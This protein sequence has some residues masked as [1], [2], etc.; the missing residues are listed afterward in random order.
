MSTSPKPSSP[1][2]ASP[3][4]FKRPRPS[5]LLM[6]LLAVFGGSAGIS[7]AQN[8]IVPKGTTATQLIV[9]GNV[10]SITTGTLHGSTALNAF[11]R[12]EVDRN[13]T[14]NLV[15]PSK[16]SVLLNMVTDAPVTINGV[17]NSLK[18]GRIG[19]NVVFADPFGM[20]VGASGVLNVGSLLVTTPT[21]TF[22]DG[23]IGSDGSINALSVSALLGGTAPDS[24]LGTIRIDGQVNARDVI[25]LQGGDVSVNGALRAGADVAHQA[26]FL[27][28]VNADSVAGG[29][30]LVENNGAIEIVASGDV[31]IGGRL[32]VDGAAGSPAGA[33]DVRAGHDLTVAP[34][35]SVSARGQGARSDGGTVYLMAAHDAL[36]GKAARLDASAGSSGNGGFIEFSAANKVTIDGGVM[37]AGAANGQA[38]TVL[39][40]P[41]TITWYGSGQDQLGTDGTAIALSATESITLDDVV[42]SSRKVD[43]AT[44]VT[45]ANIETLASTGASGNI[46]LSAPSI[47]LSGG[48]RLLAFDDSATAGA[49][50]I[51]RLEATSNKTQPTLGTATATSSILLRNATIKGND[52]QLVAKNTVDSR[53]IT[54]GDAPVDQAAGL[55]VTAIQNVLHIGAELFGANLVFSD[56]VAKATVTVG[57]GSVI[58]ARRTAALTAENETKAGIAHKYDPDGVP[59]VA[60]FGIGASWVSNESVATVVVETGARITAADLTIRAHNDASLTAQVKAPEVNDAGQDAVAIALNAT[61]A[62]VNAIARVDKG[63]TLQVSGA[64]QVAATN[65][66]NFVNETETETGAEGKGAASVAYASHSSSTNAALNANVGDATSVAILSVNEVQQDV[67]KASASVGASAAGDLGDQA[68]A[69]T[70]G[71]G[72]QAVYEFLGLGSLKLKDDLAPPGAN[73]FRIGGAIAI[74]NNSHTATA[75]IGAGANV[76]AS[77][78]ALVAARVL[79]SDIQI[80]A[81]SSAVSQAANQAKVGTARDAYSAGLAVANIT[82]DAVASVGADAVVTAPRIA[83]SADTIVPVR[84]S[85]LFGSSDAINPFTRWDGLG[86]ITAALGSITNIGDVFNAASSAKA[87]GDGTADSK[88]IYGSVS[89]LTMNDHARAEIGSGARLRVTGHAGVTAAAPWD[90]TLVLKPATPNDSL[91]GLT[92][93]AEAVSQTFSYDAPVTVSA[94]YDATYLFLAGQAPGSGSATGLGASI[95]QSTINNVTQAIV[96]EGAVIEGV[97]EHADSA[98]AGKRTWTIDAVRAADAVAVRATSTPRVISLATAGGIGATFGINGTLTHTELNSDVRALIDDEAIVRARSLVLSAT[99]TPVLWSIAGSLN[100]ASSASVGVG[101]AINKVTTTA[102]AEI[103]DNDTL[104]TD[105]AP[106][107]SVLTRSGTTPTLTVSD[108][109]VEARSGGTVGAASVAGSLAVNSDNKDPGV[110]DK[111]KAKYADAITGVSGIIDTVTLKGK[112]DAPAASAAPAPAKKEP[113]FTFAGA[114]SASANQTEMRTVARI[115]GAVIDQG[116]ATG[117]HALVVRAVGDADI[118]AA[119]GSAA[120]ALGRS[121]SSKSST[122]IAGGVSVNQL[123]NG[124]SADIV[125][126]TVTHAG[127]VTVQALTGGEQL[128]VAIA[129]AVNVSGP[130]TDTSNQLVGSISVTQTISDD[131][132]DTE[133]F[134]R[135]HVKNSSITADAASGAG[136]ARP[137]LDVTAYNRSFIGTGGGSLALKISP[138]KSETG[139]AAGVAFSFAQINT[140]VVAGIDHAKVKAFETIDVHAW[141]ATEIAAGAAFVGA[142][143]APEANSFAGSTVVSIIGNNTSASIGGDATVEA[144]GKVS[145]QAAD[146]GANAALETLIDPDGKRN[147]TA[148][149]LDYCGSVATGLTPSGSC[150]TSVAGTIQVSAGSNYGLSL[151]YNAISN[152]TSASIGQ[153]DVKAT[154]ANGTIDVLASADTSVLSVA[155]GVALSQKFAGAGSASLNFI[156]N[157]VSATVGD[158]NATSQ[159]AVLNAATIRVKASD[160]S[161]VR[162]LGGQIAVGK[163]NAVGLALTVNDS[164]GKVAADVVNARLTAA[165]GLSVEA[166]N[167]ARI[168][169]IAVSGAVGTSG[170]AAGGSLAFNFIDNSTDASL[171]GSSV[172]AGTAT[173]GNAV[174]VIAADSSAIRSLSGAAAFSSKAAGGVALS[175]NSIDNAS[176][177]RINGSQLTGVDT[178]ALNA[179]LDSDIESAAIA[180][181]VGTSAF[182]LAGSITLNEIG[183]KGNVASAELQDA[184]VTTAADPAH[185]SIDVSATDSSSIASLAGAVGVGK[186]AGFGAGVADNAIAT[187]V[188]ARV[189]DSSIHAA[190]RLDIAGSS[191]A[192]IESVAVAGAGGSVGGAGSSSTNRIANKTYADLLDAQVDGSRADVRVTA[193]DKASIDSLAGAG[194]VGGTA[195]AG[196]SLAV[197]LVGGAGHTQTAQARVSGTRAGS[198]GL[199][200]NNLL[201]KA[202]SASTIRTIAAAG[203]GGATGGVGGSV[204]TNIVAKDVSAFIDAGARVKAANNI[205]VLAGADDKASVISGALGIGGSAGIGA[206]S[207]FNQIDGS[208]RAYVD[209]AS[210]TLDAG[211]R[212]AN[213]TISVNS[214]TLAHPVEVSGIQAPAAIAA[215]LSETQLAVRGLA[216]SASSHQSVNNNA[217]S[218]GVGTVGVAVV[219]VI[220]LLGGETHAFIHGA[221]VN[222]LT[223]PAAGADVNVLA[224]SHGFAGNFAL[225]AAGGKGAATSAASSSRSDRNTSAYVTDATIGTAAT[226]TETAPIETVTTVTGGA[227]GS[228]G[229]EEGGAPQVS[230]T[231]ITRR[232]LTLAPSV[233]A[234]KVQA[235]ASQATADIVSGLAGGL[236]AGTATGAVTIFGGA[237]AAYLEGGKVT[238]DSLAVD[239]R[240]SSAYNMLAISAA[241]GVVGMGGAVGVGVADATTDAHVGNK[242]AATRST[243]LQLGGAL[244]V[245]ALTDNDFNAT[246]ASGT[247]AGAAGVAGTAA[248]TVVQNSTSAG[249]YNVAT[250]AVAPAAPAATS[251]TDASGNVVVTSDRTGSGLLP[252][253]LGAVTVD[254]RE[255]I[256]IKPIA[257]AVAVAA[258]AGVGAAANVVV[259]KSSVTGEILNSAVD[260][261]ANVSVKANSDKRIDMTGL[262]GGA[263]QTLGIGGALGVLVVGSGA[264]GA[265]GAELDKDN[266]GT[267]SQ[268]NALSTAPAGGQAANTQPGQRA[269]P[270]FDVKAAVNG[271]APDAVTARI[272]GGSVNGKAVTVAA[273]A[274]TSTGN[275]TGA[276]GASAVLG[277]GGAVGVSRVYS[278]VAASIEAASVRSGS[279][280]VHALALDG[281]SG[282]SSSVTAY[283]GG[284]G[285]VGLG[286]AVSDALI[287]NT[288]TAHADG[289]FTG[290]ASGDMRVAAADNS[291][292]ATDGVGAALGAAAVGIVVSHADKRSSVDAT[293]GNSSSVAG[294]NLLA[295]QAT[296]SAP[297]SGNTVEATSTGAAGGLLAAGAGAESVATNHTRVNAAIGNNVRLPDGNV[298]IVAT[299]DS[300]QEAAATGVAGAGLV[301]ASGAVARASS[302]SKGDH[303]TTTATLGENAVTSATRAGYLQVNASGVDANTAMAVAAAGGVI[304]G[305]AS[306]AITGGYADVNA[307]IGSGASVHAGAITVSADHI[308]SHYDRA[309]SLNAS[310]LGGSGASAS[311]MADVTVGATVGNDSKLDAMSNVQVLAD[312]LF[313]NGTGSR[314]DSASGAGGGVLNAAAASSNTVITA[315]TN[316][317]LGDRVAINSGP[318]ATGSNYSLLLRAANNM[319]V[320]DRVVLGTGGAIAGAAVASHTTANLNSDVA[321]GLANQLN[322]LAGIGIGSYVNAAAGN[323][324]YVETHGL[325][326][327]G[328]ADAGTAITANQN[329]RIGG[330]NTRIRAFGN[331]DITAGKDPSGDFNTV[332]TGNAN[333]Q[334]Y[335]Q[336]LVAVPLADAATTLTSNATLDIA[337]GAT[338]ES[339]QNAVVGAWQ[340]ASNALANGT[341]HGYELGFIPVT[342]GNSSTSTPSSANVTINGDVNAGI[343]HDLRITIENCQ[344]S[345]IYCSRYTQSANS[346]PTSVAFVPQFDAAAYVRA[347]FTDPA[348]QGLMLT[349]VATQPVGAINIGALYA[350][351]GTVTVNAATLQGKGALSSYGAPTIQVIN[352]SPD[353]LVLD[354]V[355]IPNTPGGEV[356]FSGTAGRSTALANQMRLTESGAGQVPTISVQNNY[357]GH[358]G[359]VGYGPAMMLGG[360]ITN[361]GGRI[362]LVN[363][364]GSVG[365]NAQVLGQQVNIDAPNAVFVAQFADS[366]G[367]YYAGSNPY[368]EWQKAMIWPGNNPALAL[369]LA[370]LAI[371][372]FASSIQNAAAFGT[373]TEVFNRSFVHRAG[374]AAGS[375][376][377]LI[378]YGSG[379]RH[380]D[381]QGVANSLSPIGQSLAISNQGDSYIP[382]VPMQSLTKEVASYSGADLSGS[383]A[384]SIIFGS[385]VAIVAKYI[386]V[387]GKITAGQPT[388]WSVSLPASLAGMFA[389]VTAAYRAGRGAAT[390]KID[391]KLLGLVSIGDSPIGATFDVVTQQIILDN[392]SASSGGGSVL[393]NGQILSTNPLGNIHVNGG[394]GKVNIDNQTGYTLKLQDVGAG[395]GALLAGTVGKVEIIDQSPTAPKHVLYTYTPGAGVQTYQGSV[396]QTADQLVA[397]GGSS[398]Q[399]AANYQPTENA[400]WEWTNTATLSRDITYANGGWTVIASNWKFDGNPNEPWTHSSGSVVMGSPGAPVFKETISGSD[401]RTTSHWFGYGGCD[402]A[403]YQGECNY[404]FLQTN[405]STNPY[406]G[407]WEYRYVTGAKLTLTSSVKADNPIKIDF[408]GNTSG[409]VSIKSNGAVQLAGQVINPTGTTTI[410]AGTAL[411]QSAKSSLATRDLTLNAGQGIGTSQQAIS[412]TLADNGVLNASAGAA[413]IYL[414]LAN[415]ATIGTVTAGATGKRGDVRITAGDALL[416]GNTGAANVSGNNITLSSSRGSVGND[417][418]PM[419]ISAVGNP[420]INGAL[421][422]V[423]NVA[424]HGDIKLRQVGGDLL[425]AQIA[426]TGN[427]DVDIA[428]TN[429][430]IYDARGQ[431]AANTLSN[432]Q[433]KQVWDALKLT[434]DRGAETGTRTDASVVAF[435]AQV[436]RDYQKFWD[437]RQ[438]GSLDAGGALLLDP[439]NIELL[440]TL[441]TAALKKDATNAEVVDYANAQYQ[442]AR[443]ALGNA[444]ALNPGYGAG[445]E[446]L[447]DFTRYNRQFT[448]AASSGQIAQLTKNAVWNEAQLSYSISRSALEPTPSQQVGGATPNIIGH[449]ISIDTS[450]AIGKLAPVV[451]ISLAELTS[452]AL[453]T[454]QKAALGLAKAPG[455]IK[456]TGVDDQ[457]RT[458]V[459]DFGKE[460]AGIKLTGFQLAQTSPL[461]IDATG[462]IKVNA[463]GGAV[464]L[465]GSGVNR[466][467]QIDRVSATTDVALTAPQSIVAATGAGGGPLSPVQII[468]GGDVR[469]TGGSGNLGTAVNPLNYQAGGMLQLATAGQSIFLRTPVDDML[470][471]SIAAGNLVRLYAPLGSILA[472]NQNAGLTIRGHDIV[473]NAARD[474]GM[475]ANPLRIST[476][477]MMASGVFGGSAGGDIHVYGPN[478]ADRLTIG[479]LSAGGK[480]ELGAAGAL[481]ANSLTAG[482]AIAIRAGD[483]TVGAASGSDILFAAG[484]DLTLGHVVSRDGIRTSSDGVTRVEDELEAGN[485]VEISAAALDMAAGSSINAGTTLGISTTAGN[486]VLARVSGA[487]VDIKAVGRILAAQAGINVLATGIPGQGGALTLR[488]LG[489]AGGIGEAGGMLGIRAAGLAVRTASGDL[490]LDL[491][492][493]TRASLVEAVQG[494]V[495]INA[496]AALDARQISGAAVA[497]TA[498]GDLAVG[499]L[500]AAGNASIHGAAAV[501]IET[502]STTNDADVRGTDI[503]LASATAAGDLDIDAS[504]RLR[505]TALQAG[506]DLRAAAA[507]MAQVDNAQAGAGL[508]LRAADIAFGRIKAGGDASLATTAGALRGDSL[509]TGTLAADAQ[510]QLTVRRIDVDGASTLHAGTTL[511]IATLVSGGDATVTTGSD[512]TIGTASVGTVTRQSTL[513]VRSG[514][515]LV[516]DDASASRDLAAR[517]ASAR[518]GT[519]QAE[520]DMRLA[521]TG[522]KLDSM[523]LDAGT[524]AA[525]VMGDASLARATVR[526]MATMA[527][528]GALDV[529]QWNSGGTTSF[530]AGTTAALQQVNVGAQ[531]QP[532]DLA[533]T[534]RGAQALGA[535]TASGDIALRGAALTLDTAQAGRDMQVIVDGHAQIQTAS[536][537]GRFDLDTGTANVASLAAGGAASL[538]SGGDLAVDT[539]DAGR[540]VASVGGDAAF[541]QATVRGTTAVTTKGALAMDRFTSSGNTGLD[542]GTTATLQQVAVGTQTQRADLAV[543]SSGAQA[544]GA[545]TA[546]GDIALRGAALTLDT[547]QAGRDMQVVVDGHAGM[548]AARVLGQFSLDAG[549]ADIGT[550]AVNGDAGIAIGAGKLAIATLDANSLAA[551]VQGDAVLTRATVRGATTVNARGALDIGQL[552]S[553]GSANLIAGTTATVEQVDAGSSAQL[554]DLALTSGGAQTLGTVTASGDIALRGATLLLGS[555]DAGRDMLVVTG[556]QSKLG[557]ATAGRQFALRADSARF[558]TIAAGA[559]ATLGIDGAMLDGDILRAAGA[560]LTV[561]GDARIGELTSAGTTRVRTGGALAIATLVSGSDTG[562]DA[563]GNATLGTVTVG[564]A[565]NGADLTVHAGGVLSAMAIDSSGDV[566][567]QGAA[568]ALG[569]VAAQADLQLQADALDIRYNR[570]AA[571]GDLTATVARVFQG[572]SGS[573]LAAKGNLQ[574]KAGS[575]VFDQ[576]SAGRNVSI[577]PVGNVSGNTLLA[578]GD[579]LI[580]SRGNIDIVNLRAVGAAD[581]TADTGIRIGS[582][583]A[584]SVSASTPGTLTMDLVVD[585]GKLAIGAGS[586]AMKVRSN[587]ASPLEFDLTGYR[588]GV[589]DRVTLDIDA[590]NGTRFPR[591]MAQNAILNTTADANSFASAYIVGTM[592][593]TNPSGRM[594]MNNTSPATVPGSL[595]Q[596]VQ[597]SF[598]FTLAQNGVYYATDAYATQYA[599]QYRL[600]APN[601]QDSRVSSAILYYG[602]SAVR[603]IDG[604]QAHLRDA[605]AQDAQSAFKRFNEQAR[606]QFDGENADTPVVNWGDELTA[607]QTGDIQL[608]ATSRATP[609]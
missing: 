456:V 283:A 183:M 474:L 181:G 537:P 307:A 231:T 192:Q 40:D 14:V 76:H 285:L 196:L 104:S 218:L 518:L 306:V 532:A 298:S 339:A 269:A 534:S 404:G 568:M 525:T 95:G 216:V 497:L 78:S 607:V 101:I 380:Q 55:A 84:N 200:V 122:A 206:S 369:P 413:G 205:G 256:R 548:T 59:G 511:G 198:A 1:T 243:T 108:L 577:D 478:F 89:V 495:D 262:S 546:S 171:R 233:G 38:G 264:T 596:L 195:A 318:S 163:D 210:T 508:R 219:P 544:L 506:G 159:N 43:T 62:D 222:T 314:G 227:V 481:T 272:V 517:A 396:S 248:V 290:T 603:G 557:T 542:A 153:A 412:A 156:N 323:A 132:G 561:Q 513:D 457:G 600:I 486:A 333:A 384:S 439:A 278:N 190:R 34:S 61:H 151:G 385:K 5:A 573:T 351:G 144:V 529:G 400:R 359:G 263:G 436:A 11:S 146:S 366:H 82:H 223:G 388:D 399:S 311:H 317:S 113:T 437:L 354:S 44:P 242:N 492:G 423:V 226:R 288:V 229:P 110:L 496:R 88:G 239:A 45:R 547:A 524:L 526:G 340:G 320:S 291:T 289:V 51:V 498:A 533:I 599:P 187:T 373:N 362:D 490:H 402:S 42:F 149:A 265:A 275:L 587:A 556:S 353:Y 126:T 325:A 386:D 143:Q 562:L 257:G 422:G 131:H 32:A 394:F 301:A 429:G 279:I 66:G 407:W 572:H 535:I 308:D 29:A 155:A 251:V 203:A 253:A 326:A 188:T 349:G 169:S 20:I 103:A 225:G 54:D 552:T 397:V 597:P 201:V 364:T 585:N 575:V 173:G 177:A 467:L 536:T 523:S 182:G 372:Y 282:E 445:W 21:R 328:S 416:A 516:L 357:T 134:A 295:V 191:T 224:S 358:V 488:S 92:G 129:A 37:T 72:E 115:D 175:Y 64:V 350:A 389:D 344:D 598:G 593:F 378:F 451:N 157:S 332:L 530:N 571:G 9:N 319:S 531:A 609:P 444:L 244:S 125:D 138:N 421:G 420:G 254:A 485:G 580:R 367:P 220:N 105:G 58:E 152:R 150:I 49:G 584:A 120:L 560:T 267:L 321:T 504:G 209:G 294:F 266:S 425:V 360:A 363:K 107:T 13:N 489:A 606:P 431:T 124:T 237:T 208:V 170:N 482:G 452:G 246:V 302:G 249:I 121:I 140:D 502:L 570:L 382:M 476:G 189:D 454:T 15:V 393:L 99:E 252:V 194:A 540:L 322:S 563:G 47:T 123:G 270:G 217:V 109:A 469:L 258:G 377:S 276:A 507:G 588:G 240:S 148:P 327:V 25:R 3:W 293:L 381:T 355:Q 352:N 491:W 405:A 234:V 273:Q 341:G 260:S 403:N 582:L 442:G 551:T 601:H 63:A 334:G 137:A 213:D 102:R 590:P 342:T 71:R 161:A 401:T 250:S 499:T 450:A 297:A 158:A 172:G 592:W 576:A 605:P 286:A 589:A 361:L 277:A 415:G 455:D 472:T 185:S 303:M 24:G 368:A 494:R 564:G 440:R 50:G 100:H 391:P 31:A 549:A 345:G 56:V 80:G 578:G 432:A 539:L 160:S 193:A 591:F 411:T 335:V 419:V 569:E 118:T 36:L 461:F 6:A 10:T 106:R 365:Q 468:A 426:S 410:D 471:G 387:N 23:V 117:A 236:V 331:L 447:T 519:L 12:F 180:L 550:L 93:A 541:T 230:T 116:A 449:A 566:R 466:D 26:A 559:D 487:T 83:V 85:L 154:G 162:S 207:A 338:V 509:A 543:R 594:Y 408:S 441:A 296:S 68:A 39:I 586:V 555:A 528:A 19:G 18:D 428:V 414:D 271:L 111:L 512:A 75:T 337:S 379:F 133:N 87:G 424:A 477:D 602:A 336:G 22:I 370:D 127:D 383:A 65:I 174:S 33:I 46:T 315:H 510:G 145:V 505:A 475:A 458:V 112:P 330:G 462:A 4:R 310:L 463:K 305:N 299:N 70:L 247:L 215:D 356:L 69:Q 7:F 313:D 554:A 268:V 418:A 202:D 166:G 453:S 238:A 255:N 241:A 135:A 515:A 493:N 94:N 346:A 274:S 392:V 309:N 176:R 343:F 142:S 538:A 165:S 608:A 500:A 16:A 581:L 464:Y 139:V 465:Q 211:A 81:V 57:T 438:R 232:T 484:G 446:S 329:V 375:N 430:T 41:A 558:G 433:V 86:T 130:K 221:R 74:A 235:R 522:G 479:A 28:A 91:L 483:T 212:D 261:A 52:V 406:R 97:D 128:A 565:G 179:S 164:N 168:D 395:S 184:S 35:A 374:D 567:L 595:L 259:V 98:A 292:V 67:V 136:G 300:R 460:P 27:G 284:L 312:N 459:Y 73:A 514:G 30:A 114:G 347:H 443:Q 435:E 197:N 77:E 178:L 53:F 520:R 141:N 186:D 434:A 48:T 8:V 280:D 545:I 245:T 214:G 398:G 60:P 147:S 583:H 553:G 90:T 304:A 96:R 501:D 417:S 427:G 17:V 2:T 199:D 316:V 521:T 348:T 376:Y 204:V 470:V 79:A 604:S 119:S 281:S 527:A 409:S 448:F 390:H 287:Q 324:A 503:V 371:S 480:I 473:L 228:Q 574:V 167:T 579:A